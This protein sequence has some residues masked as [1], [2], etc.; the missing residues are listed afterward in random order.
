[1]LVAISIFFENRLFIFVRTN[2]KLH[3]YAIPT[4]ILHY[5]FPLVVVPQIINIPDQE[6][7]RNNFQQ[8]F[9]CI[10]PY[11][12]IDRMFYLTMKKRYFLITCAVFICITFAEVWLFAFITDR[13][14]KKQ[15]QGSMSQNTAAVHRKFQRAFILQVTAT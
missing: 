7:G 4:Y 8:K 10:P 9:G 12:E 5:I 14:I 13:L 11:V 2:K 6:A 1:M 15:V 3:R